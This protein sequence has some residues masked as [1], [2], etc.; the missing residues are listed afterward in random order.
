MQKTILV[1]GGAGYIGSH[2]AKALALGGYFPVTLDNLVRGHRRAVRW[3]PLYECDLADKA[4]LDTVFATHR[5]DGV[6]H[7][8]AYA[9]VGESMLEPQKYFRNNVINSLNLLESMRKADVKNIVFS[10]SCATY[11]VPVKSP[12][13]EEQAQCPVSPYGESKLFV[14]RALHWQALAD[15]LHYMVLRYFN[16]SGADP[17]AEIGEDHDPETHLIPLAIETALGRRDHLEVYG[18]DFPTEDGTAIRDYVHVTDLACAHLKA[19]GQLLSGGPNLALNLGTGRG[20]SVRQ[21]IEMVGKVTNFR[22]NLKNC[23]RRPGD[24][25]CL[26]AASSLAGRTLGWETRHSELQTIVDTALRWHLKMG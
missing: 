18:T 23:P 11:G 20:Y 12:I 24:P 13:S 4:A 10:S 2:I 3:G 22:V 15:N 1:T 16:A 6:I 14:E 8:A 26:V 25:P 5:F 17:Q 21:V 9:Y 19:M 7:C